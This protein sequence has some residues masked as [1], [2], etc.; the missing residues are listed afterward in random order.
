MKPTGPSRRSTRSLVLA[1]RKL[2]TKEEAPIWKR[3]ANEIEN[4]TRRR[5]EVN[6]DK[7]CD[8]VQEKE[9]ALVPGKVLGHGKMS[10]KLTVAAFSFSAEAKKAINESG[11]TLSL[12]ELMQKNPKGKGVRLIA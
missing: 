6:L 5:R 10:K 8:Y 1:L 2:S 12:T 11:K 7:L 3:V 9:T 4:S